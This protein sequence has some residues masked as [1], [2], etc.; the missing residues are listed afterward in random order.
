MRDVQS[1][2]PGPKMK[3]PPKVIEHIRIMP[4]MGGGVTVAHHYTSMEHA[5]KTQ[6][7][8]MT[9]G[10][11]FHEH[12]ATHTGMPMGNEGE[13]ESEKPADQE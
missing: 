13:T 10:S 2:M 3:K 8:G 9:D 7:F 11:A 5:P 1:A 4:K 6:D 12:L